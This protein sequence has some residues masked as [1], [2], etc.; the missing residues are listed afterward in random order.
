MAEKLRMQAGSPDVPLI[1]DLQFH[2][3]G[4]AAAYAGEV[5]F[6]DGLGAVDENVRIGPFVVA[7]RA[8]IQVVYHEL[9]REIGSSTRLRYKT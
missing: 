6:S 9:E 1:I 7:T 2:H 8:E 3:D 5:Y 4:T